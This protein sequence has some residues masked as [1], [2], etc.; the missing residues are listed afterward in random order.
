MARFGGSRA[1]GRLERENSEY[2]RQADIFEMLAG[3]LPSNA[4]PILRHTMTPERKGSCIL[5]GSACQ[6]AHT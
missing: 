1:R 3:W 4:S 5:D 2:G 6:T